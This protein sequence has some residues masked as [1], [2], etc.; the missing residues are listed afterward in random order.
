MKHNNAASESVGSPFLRGEWI[1]WIQYINPSVLVNNVNNFKPPT[2]LHHPGHSSSSPLKDTAL[3]NKS[4]S[5]WHPGWCLFPSN[6]L[7]LVCALHLH[8]PFS[9]K[10][11]N[12]SSA[13]DRRAGMFHWTLLGHLTPREPSD[14][15]F[16]LAHIYVAVLWLAALVTWVDSTHDPHTPSPLTFFY[17]ATNPLYATC[18][19]AVHIQITMALL[20]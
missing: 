6:I 11:I 17:S 5:R 10:S 3:N 12:P 19:R 15:C 13:R 1:K 7:H 2:W 14:M 18:H 4:C 9:L 20:A 8:Q 16:F